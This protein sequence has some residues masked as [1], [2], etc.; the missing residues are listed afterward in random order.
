MAAAVFLNDWEN[1]KYPGT[2]LYSVK[3][4]VM[5]LAHAYSE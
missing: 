4:M 1:N 2:G 3:G 5:H